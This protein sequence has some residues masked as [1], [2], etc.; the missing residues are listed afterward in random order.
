MTQPGR[1]K[2]VDGDLCLC[3][4]GGREQSDSDAMQTCAQRS[5]SFA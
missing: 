2:P 5:L 1:H 3:S 4:V